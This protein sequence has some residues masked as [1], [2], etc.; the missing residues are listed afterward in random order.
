MIEIEYEL[1]F[2]A[3]YIPKEI[4]NIV[5]IKLKDFYVPESNTEHPN[6]RIRL[7]GD[8][9]EITKKQPI[10]DR[11][12]SEQSEHTIAINI[13]EFN[14]LTSGRSRSIAKDRYGLIYNG[15]KMEVDIFREN[16]SGLVL[17]DFE[18]KSKEEKE[19]FVFPDFCLTEVTQEP[20]LAGGLLAGK[21]YQ[22]IKTTLNKYNY[23]EIT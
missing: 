17:I 19:S 2:L 4:Q 6:L 16:L 14:D 12:L 9:Y 5:P 20:I 10:S 3:K 15:V 1:T 11:D 18:F 8:N 21:K 22:D 13:D 23:V 7:K